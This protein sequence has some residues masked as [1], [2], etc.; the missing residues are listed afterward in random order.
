MDKYPNFPKIFQKILQRV[1]PLFSKQISFTG[2]T[3]P[4]R[5]KTPQ[6][7]GGYGRGPPPSGVQEGVCH[8][9]RSDKLTGGLWITFREG[10]IIFFLK[11]PHKY[12]AKKV[13][14]QV[15]YMKSF[16]YLCNVV[17]PQSGGQRVRV[18]TR[19]GYTPTCLIFLYKGS[20]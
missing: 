6:G 3:P 4:N 18:F 15:V 8:P 16:H 19:R 12:T 20:G 2:L 5:P 9:L 7:E 10:G 14:I 13:N 17:H 1:Y 11:P